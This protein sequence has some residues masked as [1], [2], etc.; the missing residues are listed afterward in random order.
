MYAPQPWS[1][2]VPC[3]RPPSFRCAGMFGPFWALPSSGG[4]TVGKFG[5]TTG[6][7]I[8]LHTLRELVRRPDMRFQIGR[9]TTTPVYGL[10]SGTGGRRSKQ[11]Q[12]LC[13]AKPASRRCGLDF[14]VVRLAS[15]K[16]SS[17]AVPTQAR[18]LKFQLHTS[19]RHIPT[20]SSFPLLATKQPRPIAKNVSS[21][22]LQTVHRKTAQTH[23]ENA[24]PPVTTTLGVFFRPYLCR[25]WAHGL[26]VQHRR[27]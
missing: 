21:I 27:S 3:V 18:L 15:W 11:K 1:A 5:C 13:D 12:T 17:C 19:T 2:D 8:S 9:R 26:S 4:K 20:Q 16:I 25:P 23:H 7:T 14:T 22:E 24:F 10:V 6:R